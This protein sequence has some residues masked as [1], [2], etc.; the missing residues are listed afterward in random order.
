MKLSGENIEKIIIDCLNEERN[1]EEIIVDGI[2]NK[3]CFNKA[4]L[5]EHSE[6]IISMLNQLPEQFHKDTGGG[7]SFL[8]ACNNKD[9]EQWTSFHK[10]MDELFVLGIGIGKVKSTLPREM[11]AV[12]PGGMPYFVI[13]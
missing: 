12:L 4:K 11:W 10:C 13:E 5:K 2:L 7:W 1:D 9:G 6:S 8:N 3:F